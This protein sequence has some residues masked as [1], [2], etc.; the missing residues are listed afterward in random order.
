[1][2]LKPQLHNTLQFLKIDDNIRIRTARLG[3]KFMH[4]SHHGKLP[5]ICYKLFTKIASVHAHNFTRLKKS[6]FYAL[7]RV[8]T[9][10]CKNQLSYS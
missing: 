7:S 8:N 10:F 1:M 6:A 4:Q 5:E 2:Q 9:N 3:Y